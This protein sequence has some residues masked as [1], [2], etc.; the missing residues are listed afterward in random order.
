LEHLRSIIHH[1]SIQVNPDALL[2]FMDND[3]LCH[4]TRFC[5]M[6]DFY[7]H[8]TRDT[9]SPVPISLAL[10]CK[11]L[12]HPSLTPPEGQLENFVNM[13]DCMDMNYWKKNSFASEKIIYATNETAYQ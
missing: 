5:A 10:P 1:G 9:D 13:D 11:R 2:A 8:C 7:G 12:L 6:V 4:P 3:D